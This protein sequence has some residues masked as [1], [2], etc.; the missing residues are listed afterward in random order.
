[1]NYIIKFLNKLNNLTVAII[2]LLAIALASALGTV[3]EQNKNTDFYLKNYPLT[4]PLFNFVTSDLILKF[5]LDHV[6]TS[7]WFIFLIILLLLSLTLCTIT[8]QLPALKLARLWQFYTNFNTK[9]KFQIRFK[10]NSS[11]LTKL[12]YYLEEKNYK[13]KHFNHFV[14]AY[15]GIFG[16]VSPIIVH[17]SLVIVLIGSML[18]TT[19]GRTQEAFIVVNQ[20]KP[21]L[22]TYEAYVNDFK[23]AYNSQGLIDQFYSDLILETRQ[24]SKIQKTIYVNEPLNYSNITIYQTDW[25]I[26]NLVICIDNQN[27]YSIPLQFIELPNGSESKYW[28]NRLDLFGQSVFC[29]VNDLTGIV[30][31]Y[32]QNKDLI[33]ISSLGEFITLNGHTITFNKLVASTGLQFKLDSF[34]PLV[35]LGFLLLMISTL[36]SYISYSQVWLVKNGSTTYIFGS[37]NRAKFAFIKQLTEIANQC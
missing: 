37:T 3:I 10:T 1:M 24:A 33:C 17:F 20:E 4:K 14:Y 31:L 13:I 23:I 19:Q 6:Y 7:W 5:G 27:Y 18:S 8:R 16:R 28:I 21:V 2:I 35:Y 29:V 12:T 26:D 11:S 36:L 25:N 9:A 22:D 34:I 32:N 15:K 30:Y